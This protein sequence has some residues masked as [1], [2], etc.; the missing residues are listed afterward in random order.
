MLS[1]F[2]ESEKKERNHSS[3]TFLTRTSVQAAICRPSCCGIWRKKNGCLVKNDCVSSSEISEMETKND[4]GDISYFTH[5]GI[6]LH[7]LNGHTNIS[8]KK[9]LSGYSSR[10]LATNMK[11]SGSA[12]NVTRCVVV[13]LRSCQQSRS[14]QLPIIKCCCW[15]LFSQGRTCSDYCEIKIARGRR[16]YSCLHL[17]QVYLVSES[18]FAFMESAFDAQMFAFFTHE[19]CVW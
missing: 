14:C 4:T 13:T 9:W 3:Q 16:E 12:A 19:F 15:N 17:W 2:L 11:S 18:S 10:R 8:L 1:S 6:L 5:E 7:T